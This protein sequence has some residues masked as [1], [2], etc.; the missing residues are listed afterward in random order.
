MYIFGDFFYRLFTFTGAML[1]SV[2]PYQLKLAS[3]LLPLKFGLKVFLRLNSLTDPFSFL[4]LSKWAKTN[5]KGDL[6]RKTQRAI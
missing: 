5:D 2:A 3:P 6:P 4:L 1:L